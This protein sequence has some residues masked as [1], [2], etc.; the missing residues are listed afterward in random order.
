MKLSFQSRKPTAVEADVLVTFIHQSEPERSRDQE[1]LVNLFG[2]GAIPPL[3]IRDFAGKENETALVYVSEGRRHRRLLLA[4]LGEQRQPSPERYRR[5]AA[6]AAKKA[7]SLKAASMLFILPLLKKAAEDVIM[8]LGEGALLGLYRFD[9]YVSKQKEEEKRLSEI[10]FAS[11]DKKIAA[12]AKAALHRAQI[13]A[14]AVILARDLA[15]A[16]GNEIYPETL[17]EVAV[18]SGKKAGYKVNVLNEKEIEKLGMGGIMGVSQGSTRP[19]RFLILEYGRPSKKT[20]VLVGKGVTFDTGGISIKPSANMSEM[21]MDMSGGAAVIGA[22]EAV[23]RLKLPVHVIGLIPAVENMPSGNS[24]RPGDILR[25]YNGKTSEV[26][27]TD[28][29]GRLILADALGYAERYKPA[30]VIDLATLT[31]ACVVALGHHAT[32]MMG[33]DAGL[34]KRLKDA[35]EATYERVWELPLFDEY[36]RL[37]KSDVADVK[38]VGGRWAGAI[39]AGW[40][41]RKFIGNY[42]WIHLDI[43]GTAILEENG[44]YNQ[45]GGSGV[46]VRLLTEFLRH[47]K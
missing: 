13:I 31:G 33:N 18:Q 38:N 28:A 39:T 44:E 16:P 30:A 7:K 20:V 8:A 4:G 27:N 10:I 43:A 26:D 5:S 34:M 19:P 32:G 29:E 45:K 11:E 40:F 6:V 9:K 17:A 36:E 47:W 37:I 42:K 35:G 22:L 25:H 15:N 46:G 41:L 2:E 23:S 3:S 1:G 14:E 24:I 21:K 12:A